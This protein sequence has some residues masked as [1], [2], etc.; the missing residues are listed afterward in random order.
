MIKTGCSDYIVISD[1]KTHRFTISIKLFIHRGLCSICFDASPMLTPLARITKISF[2]VCVHHCI[3]VS[4]WLSPYPKSSLCTMRR[5]LD[6]VCSQTQCQFANESKMCAS[7]MG[8][9]DLNNH[10]QG[11]FHLGKL[12]IGL[13]FVISYHTP[14]QFLLVPLCVISHPQISC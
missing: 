7:L 10:R 1:N 11:C 14:T 6:C 12:A 2:C 3:V 5:C 9:Y 8:S 4:H 13:Y